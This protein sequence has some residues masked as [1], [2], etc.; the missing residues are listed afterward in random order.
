[1]RRA[2]TVTAMA[3]GVAVVAAGGTVA[4]LR[5]RGPLPA[6]RVSVT[7]QH[8]LVL[9]S[10]DPPAVPV[11]SAG[12]FLLQSDAGLDLGAADPDTPRPIGSVAKVMTAL[13]V[14]AAHPL[15]AGAD[16]PSLTLSAQD[17][18]F[19]EQDAAAGG[20]AIAVQAGE[21]LTERQLLLALLL[22]S[23]NNIA[24]TLAVWVSGS[25]AAFSAR[26]TGE[27][28]ALGMTQS[29]FD[30]ASGVSDATVASV[31]DL[32]RLARA[33]LAVPALAGVVQTQSATL[34]DGTV[35]RNL[36]LLLSG[37]SDWLGLKTGWTGAAGGCLLFAARH[38][39]APDAPPV[40]VYGAALSQ[41]PDA[42]VDADHPE[43]GGAFAAARDA[44]TAAFAGYTA[45][46]L[47]T[48][49]PEVAG[50]VS[51]PWGARSD[52]AVRA[53]RGTV[54]AR[55]GQAFDLSVV[56]R[57][58]A[59][60]PRAGTEVATVRGSPPGGAALDWAVVTTD[61]VGAPDWWWHLLNG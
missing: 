27:A 55:L 51:E 25:V 5:L 3:A 8:D 30:D 19:F 16:G 18:K 15:D 35:L 21:T 56:R 46:D 49:T 57:P 11:P 33:A 53:V 59:P 60:A 9:A 2:F 14:L 48:A 20:S 10:G 28:M 41:P 50:S 54:V 7:A 12:S 26:A 13:V 58:A 4:V 32:I 43:L 38:S 23:A 47:A 52:V 36:N 1:M 6:P 22:P 39:Y 40:T 34:P 37:G 17:V 61:P 45:V 24:D 31:R 44:M 29:H 42:A